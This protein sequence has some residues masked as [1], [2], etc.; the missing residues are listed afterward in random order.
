MNVLVIGSGA[1]E[2]A[3]IK[4]LK[5]SEKIGCLYI[6]PG[7]SGIRL[8]AECL[9][10]DLLL[11]K[12]LYDSQNPNP[13]QHELILSF[14]QQAGID[15][16]L[17]GPEQ[18]LVEGLGNRLKK[19]KIPF[20]GTDREGAQLE[21][22]KLYAKRF[23]QEGG[24]PTA[25]FHSVEKV[26]EALEVAKHYTPPYVFKYDGLAGGKGVLLCK[27]KEELQQVAE[28]VLEKNIFKSPAPPKALIEEHQKGWEL[29]ITL[30]T[31][32]EDYQLFPFSQD[33]KRL[34]AH[35]KGPNTGGMG[36]Y[37]P[38][39][40][41]ANLKE[42]LEKEIIQK[43]VQHIKNQ[44]L[45]YRG[46]L[47]IGIMMTDSGPKVLEFNV[48]L[49]DPE[50]QVILPLLDGDWTDV[51]YPLAKEGKL[52]PC[53][54]RNQHAC[55]V[56]LAAEGY[57]QKIQTG[58][59]IKGDISFETKSQYFLHSGTFQKN[60]YSHPTPTPPWI[61]QGGRVLSAMGL[62]SSQEEARQKAY[63]QS[64]K[65]SWKGIQFREDIASA[66]L[67]S[68]HS[69]GHSNALSSGHPRTDSHSGKEVQQ[70]NQKNQGGMKHL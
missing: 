46:I 7:N 58:S 25:S 47:Y 13:S 32:G 63:D 43:C 14:C 21:G 37:A 65:V 48:R 50:A 66:P 62:G 11:Q 26:S 31:N 22:S 44:S 20:L 16:V 28:Q 4:A 60:P 36:A 67:S 49:G 34:Y 51:F 5:D 3:L 19:A 6:T 54:W 59:K 39:S 70:G 57:P 42:V 55:C 35:N 10:S 2:H 61:I 23:L 24:I 18:P 68:D 64:K 69:S 33:H 30:L 53:Q 52:P 27:D 29:S 38:L 12:S 1:R 41:P 40:L 45:F 9:S 17:V 15:L 8:D 56:V